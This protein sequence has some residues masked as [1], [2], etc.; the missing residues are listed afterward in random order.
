M[1]NKITHAL[2]STSD[3]TG[4]V[5]FAKALVQSGVTLLTTGGTAE[6]LKRHQ[7]PVIE[8]AQFINFPEMMGGR[9]KTLHPLIYGGILARGEIDREELLAQNIPTIGL[10]VVNL[11]PFEAVI[12]KENFSEEEA[13]ENIDIG[14]P[15]LIRA[16]AKN[17][18]QTTIAIHHEDFPAILAE[19]EQNGG[20]TRET[21]LALARKAFAHVAYYDAIISH[22]FAT[23]SPSK[24]AD[25]FPKTLSLP[26]SK[27]EV[28]RYGENPHQKAAFYRLQNSCQGTISKAV[29]HSGKALSYNN[30]AD[31]DA[32]LECVKQFKESACV[33]VKH[34]N[35]CAV[36][37]GDNQ[38][39]AYQRA[40]NAD[41]LSAFGGI[42]AF[43][44]DLLAATVES[45]LANQ[46]VELIIAP[47]ATQEALNALAKKPNIR[48]LTTGNFTT[49]TIS[50]I[51]YK[52]VNGGML[53]QERD[54]LPTPLEV[55]VVTKRQPTS[56]ETKDLFFAWQVV[57]FVKSNAIVLAK[58][59]ATLGIGPG[60]VSRIFSTKIA[61]LK[62]KENNHSI[63]GCAMASDAFFPF[64]DSIDEAAK[65]GISS[66]IQP[67]GSIKDNEIIE[68]ANKYD[69]AML[70]TSRRHFNH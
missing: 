43:N 13:I 57:R 60:Q 2:L 47:N 35:P 30:I 5:E 45:I 22:Y 42:I 28:L 9:V 44:T 69:I 46:F 40:F 1:I 64:P 17:Y 48:V 52:S 68:A 15:S 34:A 33:I 26:L 11:Y 25:Y 19:I 70:F 54:N 4:I 16:A 3:K 65:F 67:G 55:R 61:L 50:T 51:E 32:A 29:Q 53:V 62:A 20:T 37:L 24:E 49:A 8:I 38:L 23:L 39:E 36:A 63:Q 12:S 10:V 58:E 7:I 31:A 14:G 6:L 18:S 41:P 59:Q 66:I 27:I 21:R 56:N